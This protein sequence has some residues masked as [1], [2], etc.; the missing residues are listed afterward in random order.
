MSHNHSPNAEL[1]RLSKDIASRIS[2]APKCFAGWFVPV[3]KTKA[4]D[5]PY[6]YGTAFGIEINGDLYLVTAAHV[7]A[8]DPN[9]PSDEPGVGLVFSQGNL[10]NLT[11]YEQ[12]IFRLPEDNS[13]IDVLAIQP[14]NVDLRKVFAGFFKKEHIFPSKLT[15]KHYLAACGFPE[16]KNRRA[17]KALTLAQRPYSYFG[18]V[19][20]DSKR[21][22][23]GFNESHFCIDFDVKWTYRNGFGGYKAPAPNGISGGPVFV[24]HD[25]A[26]PSQVSEP[27][28]V[29]IGIETRKNMKCFVCVDIRH[30][31]SALAAKV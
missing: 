11:P 30:L 21:C 5:T 16:T 28:L 12:T 20:A 24:V 23:L 31:V 13:T 25:F 29:G 6:H 15:S 1:K 18:P 27:Y 14:K 10:A 7:L 19:S 17:S 9:N 8:M 3:Y 26:T 4:D 2:E 22:K